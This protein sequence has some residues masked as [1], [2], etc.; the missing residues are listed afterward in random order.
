MKWQYRT[1]DDSGDVDEKSGHRAFYTDGDE[2]NG[3]IWATDLLEILNKLGGE[4]WELAAV[5][6]NDHPTYI[7]KR[8]AQ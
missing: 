7:F 8:P 5:S 4:G 2:D 6:P 1:L 3:R